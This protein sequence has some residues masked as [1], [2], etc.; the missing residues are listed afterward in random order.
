MYF[1]HS[2]SKVEKSTGSKGFIE[3]WKFNSDFNIKIERITNIGGSDTIQATK[4]SDRFLYVIDGH[5]D[6]MVLMDDHL[7]LE[8]NMLVRIPSSKQ[9]EFIYAQVKYLLI[10]S[11]NCEEV[12]LKGKHKIEADSNTAL[13]FLKGDGNIRFNNKVKDLHDNVLVTLTK[14]DILELNGSSKVLKITSK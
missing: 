3:N 4:H 11:D 13:Y 9:L 10:N 6:D 12:E 5:G 2:T 14:G 7:V 8:D 1:S